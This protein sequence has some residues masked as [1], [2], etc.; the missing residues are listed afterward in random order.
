MITIYKASAGSGK[1]FNLARQYIKLILGHKTEEGNYVLN[2]PGARSGHRAVLAM[3]FTNKA[4]EEMKSRIIHELA[5]LAGSEKGWDKK[6]PYE[7]TLCKDFGCS[8][9]QLADAA[10]DALYGLLYDFSRFSVSTIDSFFQTVLRAFAHE[11]DVSSNYALEIEDKDVI[12]MSVD[13]LLQSLNHSK[14]SAKTHE[15]E[16]WITRY[17]KSLIDEGEQFALFNR[18]GKVQSNLIDFIAKIHNDTFKENEKRILDYLTDPKLFPEFCKVIFGAAKEVLDETV[19]M[20][21]EA[22]STVTGM[23]NVSALVDSNVV[24]ALR[25]WSTGGWKNK[26]EPGKTIL[27][28]ADDPSKM[29]KSKVKEPQ[30][31][32]DVQTAVGLA[33][34]AIVRCYAR[35]TTLNVIKTNLYQLGLLS[36][37]LELIDRFRREN[38]TLLLSDTN[39]LLSRIIG[40]DDSPF[41]YEKLGVRYHHYLVDEFQDTSHSQWANM[42]PLLK[43]SLAYGHDNL[44]IGDEKQC[45]YRFRNS[46]PSL[47]H[48]LHTE[49]WAKGHTEVRGEVVSENTNWRSSSEV[50]RFNNSLFSS[51]ARQFGLDDVYSNV[52]QQVSE[53][54]LDHHGYVMLSCFDNGKDG[55]N[56]ALEQ[57]A[58]EMRRQLESGYTPGDIAV[59][60]RS[61]SDGE[62]VIKYLEEVRR[63]DPTY[64]EFDIIS[65]K[66][67]L[68]S[69]SDAVR[70]IISRLRMLS[71]VDITISGRNSK[72]NREVAR[73][74]NDYEKAFTSGS[75]P[76]QALEIALANMAAR[77]GDGDAP[78]EVLEDETLHGVDLISLVESI[79]STHVDPELR[80]S[81]SVFITAFVDQLAKFVSQGH[82]DI[83][84]F[85]I[86]WDEKGCNESILGS[87]D[88]RALNILTIHKSKGLEFPCVHIPFAGFNSSGSGDTGWFEMPHIEGVPDE[89]LPP[90]MPITVNK[91]LIYTP[92]ADQ[93]R[94]IKS[95]QVLDQTN[96]LYVAF[97]RAVDELI[98][99]VQVSKKIC[100]GT[101]LDDGEI[102]SVA[103]TIFEGVNGAGMSEHLPLSFDENFQLIIGAPTFKRTEVKE[104]GT[105][106]R[107]SESKRL[108]AY[109][110]T[111]TES[112]WKNTNIDNHR[113]NRIEVARERGLI[114]HEL[115]AHIRTAADIDRAFTL[116]ES[117][118]DARNLTY[119]DIK[120]MRDIIETRVSDPRA[121]KW[122][123]GFTKVYIER[124][125]LTADGRTLRIDRVVRTADGEL[126]VIDYK[127]GTQDPAKYKK[128]VRDYMRFFRSIG[129]PQ[130]QGFL[131]YLDTGDIVEI[132]LT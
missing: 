17:M 48:N 96:V 33:M 78:Q 90:M 92:F 120:T 51:I 132:E 27:K 115:M 114:L 117:S 2:R 56:A 112:V 59:L 128:Q 103:R 12:M 60:V 21:I 57:M 119:A 10:R 102:P 23:E 107:P 93:Y 54:N 121:T 46:D 109:E 61:A 19:G 52:V 8:P 53:P 111:S 118:P 9:E 6:S 91:G 108:P 55:K 70:N 95:Q 7:E 58:R 36:V 43:E 40:G 100:A 68:I 22:L 13:Q 74:L 24:K 105:A 125:I 63:E 123:E 49:S 84:S 11:A 67:L 88:N 44:V 30:K 110:S 73:I 101:P 15:I 89:L 104:K 122:F 38:S 77:S 75:T 39:T 76:D 5:V 124:E 41:L 82:G 64:P 3:T 79:I 69:S 113:L 116:L 80:K 42:R 65:D 47:L 71:S 37:L 16:T 97:T 129:Y 130:I 26:K 25:S 18:T 50:V 31:D 34:N 1:T 81:D 35:V 66:S 4:T 87:S 28:V 72:S 14:P 20:C 94:E 99:G 62:K 131:Y 45:I 126:H 127:S 106:M 98:V 86:W 32:P 29:W 85:L 83:R